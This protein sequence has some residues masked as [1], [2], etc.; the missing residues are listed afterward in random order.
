[1]NPDQI[2]HQAAA[3]P[4]L[5]DGETL[6]DD[7]LGCGEVLRVTSLSGFTAVGVGANLTAPIDGCYVVLVLGVASSPAALMTPA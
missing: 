6:Y 5:R 3:Q 7:L 4:A 1:M 2:D